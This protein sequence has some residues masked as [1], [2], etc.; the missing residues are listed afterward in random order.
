MLRDTLGR[1]LR[2]LRISV[3]DRC[4]MRCRYCMPEAEYVWLPRESI[5]SFEEIDRLVGIVGEL[6]VRKIRLT[7]GEPL[8]R[9]DL[10]TLV[11]LLDRHQAIDDIAL[12]TN[13]ILLGRHAAALRSAGLRR[14]TV[15]LDTLQPE[16]MVA[17]AR[18]ARHAE[19]LEGIASA[20]AAGFDAVKL[21]T[22]VIR[23]HNADEITALLEFARQ[24]GLE[25]RF[26]EYMDVGGATQWSL[27]QVVSRDEILSIIAERYGP[28]TPVRKDGWAPADRFRLT[29]GTTFGVIASTTIHT[30]SGSEVLRP[31][32]SPGRHGPGPAAISWAWCGSR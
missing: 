19:V 6:G 10:A 18:S 16:R 9:H 5:L 8:L 4:N 30:P 11:R 15:S 12:T 13:G 7:G 26:I 1:P 3:T 28:V 22:V 2:N 25:I 17:F 23:D 14:V 31:L 21:N 29:D 24:R 32:A 20:V 27:G